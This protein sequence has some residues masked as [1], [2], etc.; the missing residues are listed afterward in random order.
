M[1]KI[2]KP[3][4]LGAPA[5]LSV[6]PLDLSPLDG[7]NAKPGSRSPD[8]PV[9]K[10]RLE[11][12]VIV[13]T[14]R[15]EAETVREQAYAE[16]F[17]SGVGEFARLSGEMLQRLESMIDEIQA[18]RTRLAEEVEGELL[19]LCIQAVEKVIR[20]EI[21]TDPRVVTR[22]IASLLRRVKDGEDVTVRVSPEEVEF[23]RASREE[24]LSIAEGVRAVR[25]VDD[26]R[27]GPGGCVVECSSGNFDGR[28]TTQIERLSRRLMETYQSDGHQT[29][30]GPGEVQPGDKQ[31]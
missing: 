12:E 22:V 29:N 3:S 21:R 25:V 7:A 11:A 13:R 23:V 15:S 24:L 4:L 28:V 10:A 9:T 2:I 18:E 14:A 26:R 20:H 8:D 17:A 1:N 30:P 19:K 16:G 31:A 27:V 6:A 5:G